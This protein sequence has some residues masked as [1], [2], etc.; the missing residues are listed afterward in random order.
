MLVAAAF[1]LGLCLSLQPPINAVMARIVGSSLLAAVLSIT[2]SLVAV[3]AVW[4]AWGKGAGD[5]AAVRAL[6]WWVLLGGLAGAA[7]VAGSIVVAPALGLALF[8]VCVVAGQLAG[9]AL[10]DQ[11]GAFGLAPRPLDAPRLVGLALV[12]AGALLVRRSG[13]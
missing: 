6:P 11:L 5:L 7:F 4:A 9:A 12:L 13:S 10:A 3:V 2:I 8:F 1:A